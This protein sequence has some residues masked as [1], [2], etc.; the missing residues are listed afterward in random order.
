V[1]ITIVNPNTLVGV[2]TSPW[3]LLQNATI[4]FT[5][6]LTE[7]SDPATGNLIPGDSE[8]LTVNAYFKKAFLV[9]D[10]GKGVPIGSYIVNGYT[11]GILPGWA[12]SPSSPKLKCWVKDLGTGYLQFEGKIHVVRDE[13]E[14]AGQ[15]SQIQGYFTLG[16]SG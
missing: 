8:S 15:G 7:I 10:Q 9:A 2:S 5:R 11:V 12:K 13:V 1:T 3:A 14:A 6:T 16:G 4:T